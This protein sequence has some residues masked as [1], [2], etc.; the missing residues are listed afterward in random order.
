MGARSFENICTPVRC[1]RK[2]DT[3]FFSEDEIPANIRYE[4]ITTTIQ[5]IVSPVSTT[6]PASI[7]PTGSPNPSPYSFLP[8]SST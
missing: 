5:I 4:A 3:R 6:S 8:S 7:I 2:R 1:T